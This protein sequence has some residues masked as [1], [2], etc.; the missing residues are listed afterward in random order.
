MIVDS[1]EHLIY[2]GSVYPQELG[3]CAGVDFPHVGLCGS[4]R[5][6]ELA[7]DF[8]GTEGNRAKR[9]PAGGTG[10][11]C[12]HSAIVAVLACLCVNLYSHN[13]SA[14][15]QNYKPFRLERNAPV[16]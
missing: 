15:C 1:I 6:V 2:W 16:W 8:Q 13:A 9:Y 11:R 12:E 7:Q 14:G 5:I 10:G 4:Q 3:E